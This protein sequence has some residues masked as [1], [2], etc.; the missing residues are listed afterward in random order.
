LISRLP[1]SVGIRSV[2]NRIFESD[3]SSTHPSGSDHSGPFS[4]NRIDL[5]N[6]TNRFFCES[7]ASTGPVSL[8]NHVVF[9]RGMTAARSWTSSAWSSLLLERAAGNRPAEAGLPSGTGGLATV[10]R[11]ISSDFWQP[12][13]PATARHRT[14]RAIKLECRDARPSSAFSCVNRIS[15]VFPH[16][17]RVFGEGQIL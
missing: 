8:K 17:T 2:A 10:Y 9:P 5:R 1:S 15:L 16:T 13:R 11:T 12:A 7:T 4:E 6:R 3:P 14:L